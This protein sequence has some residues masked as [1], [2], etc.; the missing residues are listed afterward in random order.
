M[1]FGFTSASEVYV[2]V[3]CIILGIAILTPLKC[4]VSAPRFMVDYYKYVSGD[5]DAKPTPPIFWANILTFYSAVS[6]V[7]QILFAPTVL[8]RTVR[9][10]SLSTRFTLAITSMMIEI[11]AVLFMPVVK[12]TQTVAIVVFFIAII[13]S[14]IGK[15][16]MEATTYTLVSSMPSKFMSAAMFGCSFSGVITS[17]LQCVIKGSMENTYESVLK[18][19]YIYFSLGLVIMTVALI[20][21]HSLRYISY[22][23]ENVAEYRMMKQ[24]NSDEGGCH[25]DTDGENEPVAKMEEGSVDEE[26]GMTTAEQLTATPV[27]PVLKK[28]HLMMT[29]CFISFFV[30]LFIFP[31][32][33]F[34]I[35]RDHNWFGTLAILCYNFGDAAGRFGTTFKCIWPSRRVLLILTLSRFL[36]IV[37]IFLCVFKYIPGHAVPYILMFLVG[38]TNYTGALSMVYGPITPGLVTAGQKLM[39]GQLMGISLLAGA[40]FASLIAIG[41]VYALP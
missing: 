21:A 36:F 13:L 14:G 9:R 39:A 16:H 32:L 29:T 3:T 38:L 11:V 20:M 17:V 33:V 30:T 31:S 24:A 1:L 40:S 8:T 26:A 23:Q 28:I 5:P 19:S 37:P 34:P 22:A 6:L 15:S 27:L 35:D 2:Y 4:L 12:V 41:V 25:N 7:T 18:Q 10:L